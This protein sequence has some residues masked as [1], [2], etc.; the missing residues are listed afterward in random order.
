VNLQLPGFLL[1]GG[2]DP[3]TK[4]EFDY[5]PFKLAFQAVDAR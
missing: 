3:V 2:V 1:G 4:H 5:P